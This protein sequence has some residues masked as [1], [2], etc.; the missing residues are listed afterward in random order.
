[1]R[2]LGPATSPVTALLLAK[3]LGK[4]YDVGVKQNLEDHFKAQMP[5]MPAPLSFD[6]LFTA[7]IPPPVP[8][9]YAD[10][11]LVVLHIPLESG[12]FHP[13]WLKGYAPEGYMQEYLASL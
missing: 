7:K 3:R 1:M 2:A 10:K 6:N 11:P 12:V 13:S 9:S 8:P 5:K 4:R